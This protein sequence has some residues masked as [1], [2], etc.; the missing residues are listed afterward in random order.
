MRA[1]DVTDD[2][3]AREEL[4]GTLAVGGEEEEEEKVYSRRRKMRRRRRREVY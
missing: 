2:A 3:P 1:E 4:V